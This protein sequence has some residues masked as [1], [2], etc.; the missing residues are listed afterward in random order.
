MDAPHKA[1]YQIDPPQWDQHVT[2]AVQFFGHLIAQESINCSEEAKNGREVQGAVQV[3][4]K[5]I[6]GQDLVISIRPKFLVESYSY[7]DLEERIA[8]LESW[9]QAAYFYMLERFCQRLYKIESIAA[10][11]QTLVPAFQDAGSLQS[12]QLLRSIIVRYAKNELS[13]PT[14]GERSPQFHSLG[15]RQI[16]KVLCLLSKIFCEEAKEIK[17]I[18]EF[19]P[20]DRPQVFRGFLAKKGRSK[21][22]RII[23]FALST[24]LQ[25]MLFQI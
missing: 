21:S 9:R 2:E 12:S 11:L 14:Q 1:G 24:L 16:V 8:N 18:K 6:S 3:P 13:P 22:Q 10:S 20:G 7:G 19:P 5:E 23:L 25:S 4:W 17:Q 15:D